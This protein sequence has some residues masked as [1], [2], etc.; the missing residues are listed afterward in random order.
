MKT[1]KKIVL[2]L[3]ILIGIGFLLP[4]NLKMPVENATSKDYH[5]K[6]F[7]YY[8]WGKSITHKG[9][10][11]FAKAGT[12]IKSSVKGIVV[13]SGTLSRGGNVV[14]ILGAK[15]RLHYFAHLQERLVSP[16]H[17]VTQN[18]PIGKVG[19][20]GNAKGKPAHLHYSIFTPF[21]YFWRFDSKCPQ[22]YLKLFFL[23]PI[24]YLTEKQ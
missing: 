16:M 20:S 23:N 15:W 4:Q 6:S 8:P 21:P 12:P 19:T 24:D 18:T 5:P 1:T 7:W 10:D 22:G 3:F 17:F 14:V 9:V 13:F 2:F 11:I